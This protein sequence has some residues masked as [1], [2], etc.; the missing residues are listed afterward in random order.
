MICRSQSEGNHSSTAT[1][2]T[3]ETWFGYVGWSGYGNG[4][5][6]W[7]FRLDIQ[8]W[9]TNEKAIIN[10]GLWFVFAAC[11]EYFDLFQLYAK[12]LAFLLCWK[13]VKSSLK[14]INHVHGYIWETDR[15]QTECN[16]LKHFFGLKGLHGRKY[17]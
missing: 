17:Q 10:W 13:Y 7:R 12:N 14:Y 15:N 2:L 8:S 9:Q 6:I 5:L 4:R 1:S 3:E 16:F 11:K